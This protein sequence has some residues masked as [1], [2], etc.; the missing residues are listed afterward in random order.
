MCF[1]P[2]HSAA[3]GKHYGTIRKRSSTNTC[4]S[5]T[6]RFC[7]RTRSTI[8]LRPFNE[9]PGGVRSSKTARFYTTKKNLCPSAPDRGGRAIATQAGY[10]SNLAMN[11]TQKMPGRAHG[12]RAGTNFKTCQKKACKKARHT[13]CQTPRRHFA[14]TRNNSTKKD[15]ERRLAKRGHP[16]SP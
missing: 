2:K 1:C 16:A 13:A 14:Q 9:F 11:T 15:A 6:E 10:F 5:P 4:Q 8:P 7:D 3:L 12:R